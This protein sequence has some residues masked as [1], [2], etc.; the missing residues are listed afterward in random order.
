MSRVC[1]LC[2]ANDV[3]LLT[4]R[5]RF[6]RE[7]DVC[8]C[9][10][11]SL[12]YLDQD[13]FVFPEDFYEADYHQTY[14]THVEPDA[15]DPQAYYDKM[16]KA[17]AKWAEMLKP[18]FRGDEKVLDVGCSTGHLMTAIKD[19]VGSVHGHDLNVK[20]V[21]FCRNTLGLDVDRIPLDERFAEGTFDYITMIFVLEHIAEPVEFLRYI[22]KFLKPGGKLVILVPNIMD[23]LVNFYDIPEFRAFYYCIEHV[24]YYSEKTIGQL[25]EKAGF[26]GEVRT[27]Q[28]YPLANHLNWAYMRKPSDTLAARSGLPNV[29]LNADAP[30][31]EWKALWAR[32][33]EIYREFLAGQGYGDRLWCVVSKQG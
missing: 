9:G 32:F 5:V 27:L 30:A 24:F 31:E 3:K 13:S 21:E 10:G 23:P 17:T 22:G 19:H 11:C 15:F 12:V 25:F 6:D 20:E 8:R 33:N 29:E 14:I 7:A 16:I 4:S 2:G 28:E 1:P 26:A 18:M